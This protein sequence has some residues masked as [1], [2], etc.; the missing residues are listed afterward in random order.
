MSFRRRIALSAAGLGV[1]GVA[2]YFAYTV[3]AVQGQGTLSQSPLNI[4]SQ[5][6]PAFVMA[7]DDSGSM[8]FE[9]LFKPQDGVGFWATGTAATNG[10]FNS[11][12][13]FRTSGTGNNHHL[14][15][16]SGSRYRIGTNRYAIPPLDKFGFARSPE[17]NPQYFN[18]NVTYLPWLNADGTP[19]TNANTDA[20]GNATITAARVD[21]R[22]AAP[23][24]NFTVAREESGS[25]Q[26]RFRAL[27]QTVLPAG[28]R[29]NAPGNCGGL[30]TTT[31][32]RNVWLTLGAAHTMT[33]DCEIG[34]SY[35]PAVFYLKTTTAAP[36]GF[37]L[38][39]RI[40][41]VAHA[42]GP[43]VSM[44]K[45]EIKLANYSSAAAYNAAIQN[46]ANWFSYYGNRNRAMIAAMTHALSDVN[47]MRVGMF[48]INAHAG[49]DNPVAEASERVAMYDM[50]LGSTGRT[51]LYA[52]L[53]GLPAS[54]GTPNRQAVQAMGKQF[55][56]TDAG[57]PALLSCQKNAGMLF[58]DGYSNTDGPNDVGNVDGDMGVPF[59]DG[60]SNTLA[61]IA[62]Q[63]YRQNL[64]PDL[65]AGNVPVPAACDAANPDNS[66]D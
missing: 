43:N 58:T 32:T 6:K 40:G 63:Y 55:L 19:H 50:A 66:L 37:V 9:T 20:S 35:F 34:I 26:L 36:A 22:D 8:T 51:S 17:Y 48:T 23:T 60:H 41:P 54:G 44:Y 64:R 21:P 56:R 42:G 39:N 25:A 27:N 12:G 1:L 3:F 38:N 5:I 14:I 47:N 61:D 7:V 4:E 24:I 30:G 45:Y 13:T 28:T 11:D 62:T 53:V 10:Y 29:Y 16:H 46:F 31:A 15:P 59:A 2:G 65:A 57:A 33:A 18:P 49:H 52:Q